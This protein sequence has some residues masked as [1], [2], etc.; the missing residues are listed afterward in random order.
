MQPADEKALNSRREKEWSRGCEQKRRSL[1]SHKLSSIRAPY[2]T[3][4]SLTSP[5]RNVPIAVVVAV[6]IKDLLLFSLGVLP[7]MQVK[8]KCSKM[9]PA[10]PRKAAQ[11]S[12][13]FAQTIS[14]N[15][16]LRQTANNET[17]EASVLERKEHI[18]GKM[19]PGRLKIILLPGVLFL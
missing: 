17:R 4:N 5:G 14:Y 10:A 8:V 12:G 7:R 13:P 3:A 18:K 2:L 11:S 9:R 1:N 19:C 15:I 16:L 6:H